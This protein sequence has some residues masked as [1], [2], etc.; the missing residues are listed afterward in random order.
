MKRWSRVKNDENYAA[1]GHLDLGRWNERIDVIFSILLSGFD[2]N[3][4]VVLQKLAEEQLGR[5]LL[6]S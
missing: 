2:N 5:G 6:A 1:P 4:Q 3:M